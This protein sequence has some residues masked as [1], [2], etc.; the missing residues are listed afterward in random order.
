MNSILNILRTYRRINMFGKFFDK[1]KDGLTK[2]RNTLTEKVTEVLNLAVT[3]DEDLY[4]E[5][6]LIRDQIESPL[7]YTFEA[8]DYRLPIE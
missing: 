4:E 7:K 1:L 3:I 6:C 8:P 5:F 2:T